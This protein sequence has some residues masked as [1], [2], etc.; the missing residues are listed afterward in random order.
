MPGLHSTAVEEN[1]RQVIAGR[2]VDRMDF[3]DQR[4]R[5]RT[6]PLPKVRTT[7]ASCASGAQHLRT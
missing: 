3:L 7:D 2:L 1:V 5:R 4:R 6:A